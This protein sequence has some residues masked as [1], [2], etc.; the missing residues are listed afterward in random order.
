[1]AKKHPWCRIWIKNGFQLVWFFGEKMAIHKHAY[2]I[3]TIYF[4]QIHLEERVWPS[5][6]QFYMGSSYVSPCVW[7]Y[8][9]MFSVSRSKCLSKCH[10]IHQFT[11]WINLFLP[12]KVQSFQVCHKYLLLFYLDK[13]VLWLYIS[14]KYA[15]SVDVVNRLAELIHVHPH[16]LLWKITSTIY[17]YDKDEITIITTVDLSRSYNNNNW[18]TMTTK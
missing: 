4:G 8:L 18:F 13:N 14:V 5:G 11:T 6:I 16:L 10:H 15:I 7:E 9:L 17:R 3:H 12:Y 2:I 1:M